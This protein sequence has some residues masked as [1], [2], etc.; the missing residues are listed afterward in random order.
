MFVGGTLL[1]NSNYTDDS[2]QIL[3]GLDAVRKRPGMYIGS[4]D[5][6][7]LHHLVYE[8]TDNAVDEI[9]NGFGDKIDIIIHKDDSITI[10]DNGRGLPTGK[11]NSG[12]ST[13]EVI[14]TVLH[15]GGK[16]GSGGYKTSG[17]LHGVG[18]SVVNALSEWLE[19]EIFRDGKK[20]FMSF[21][22]G[23][24]VNEPLKKIGNTNRTGTS[25]TFKPDQ[26]VFKSGVQFNFETIVERMRESAFLEKNLKV[27]IKDEKTDRAEEFHYEEGLISFINFLHEGKESF[28]T[29][30]AFSGSY[31]GMQADVAFQYNDQ[32]TETVMS[33]VNNVRTK[34][35]G[36][37]EVGF[38]SAFTRIFNEFARK[39]GELK[40]KDKNLE[41][42]DI[43]EGLTAVISVKIPEELLQFEGQTKGKL[44]TPEARQLMDYVLNENLPYVLEENG[45]VSSE[46]VKKAIKARQVREAA[47][48]AREDMRSGKKSKRKDALLSGKLTPAQSRNRK[49]NELFLVEGDSAG[50]SAKLGRDRKFQAILPLRGKVINTERARFEDIFKNEEIN[51]IIHTIGAGVGNEFDIDE[52]NYDKIIIMTDADTDG[53]HIQVL[54]LTF[55]FNYMRPLFEAGKIYIALP[56]LFKLESKRGKKKDIRYV[57]TEE[58]LLE[59][60]EELND[61]VE[62]QRYK[63]LGEMMADQLWET[64]MDPENRTLIQV[65]VDDEALSLKRVS[66][67]MGDNVQIR[68]DWIEE[69]VSFTL[70]DDISIL[71]SDQID[72]LEDGD[73]DA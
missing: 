62:I 29:P 63:G 7:G 11:H 20:Y 56:P 12:K 9:I 39:I 59:M 4:T 48:K 45:V 18:A 23:G 17:G 21:K 58:E 68:R 6:R 35:G 53:A 33:F 60:R 42:N 2:I 61:N 30:V 43:R 40:E 57:W 32:Y 67:L 72:I 10:T 22:N 13:P 54:L 51:T 55:F 27:S 26:E 19:L 50:G 52:V 37:H 34:D 47:R 64:T 44:G 14:F 36:T 25:V 73:S 1:A 66:T 71:D 15:A 28:G 5:A 31:N 24:H 8:I 38:K 49:K 69:N 65:L 3:E 70:G 16:F 41:G 46:L